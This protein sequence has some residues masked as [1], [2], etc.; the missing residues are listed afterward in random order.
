MKRELFV[1]VVAAVI[2]RADGRVLLAQRLP[3]GPHGGLWEFPGGKVEAGETPEQALAREIHEEL[4]VAVVVGKHLLTVEHVY[5]H[6]KI[7][8]MAY[9]CSL[10]DG[11]PRP[12]HCQDLRWASPTQLTERPMPAADLPIAEHFSASLASR[13]GER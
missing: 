12:L 3:G 1:P 6:I 5:P 7:R 11:A 2:R 8:L 10:P 13:R 9:V 4:G